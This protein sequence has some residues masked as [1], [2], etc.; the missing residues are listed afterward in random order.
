MDG[1]KVLHEKLKEDALFIAKE[2][3]DKFKWWTEIEKFESKTC[4]GPFDALPPMLEKQI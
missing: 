3:Y 4:E 1:V 2:Y